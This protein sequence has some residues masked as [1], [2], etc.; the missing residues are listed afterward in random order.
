MNT[1]AG[2][3]RGKKEE[4]STNTVLKLSPASFFERQINCSDCEICLFRLD[5][6]TRRFA[7]II[8]SLF[9]PKTRH[10]PQRSTMAQTDPIHPPCPLSR[11]LYFTFFS[12][13]PVKHCPRS[14]HSYS[15]QTP[16][17]LCFSA[18]QFSYSWLYPPSWSSG[19][20]LWT[21]NGSSPCKGRCDL[22]LSTW[23]KTSRIGDRRFKNFGEVFYAF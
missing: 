13:L 22:F 12:H 4:N 6:L 5:E 9:I 21:N 23:H 17:C 7:Y 15:M 8:N 14:I 2:K 3:K 16:L 18:V 11:R 20:N 1:E 19:R 10:C